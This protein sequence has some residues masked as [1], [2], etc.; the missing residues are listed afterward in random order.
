MALKI[1]LPEKETQAQSPPK[2]RPATPMAQSQSATDQ[3][4]RSQ[5]NEEENTRVVVC[6]PPESSRIFVSSLPPGNPRGIEVVTFYDDCEVLERDIEDIRP[7]VVLLSPQSRNY[8]NALVARLHRRSD[9]MVVVVGLVPPAG[10]WG[11]EMEA[12]GAAGFLTTP[13]TQETVDRFVRS[14]PRWIKA[15]AEERSSPAFLY[16]LTPQ[17]AAAM[18]AQGYQRGVYTSWSTKGGAGKTTVACNLASLLGVISQRPTLL[19]D[20][21]MNGGHVWLHMG[22]KPKRN[23]YALA[24][25]FRRNGNRLEPRD[26]ASQVTQYQGALDILVGIMRVEQ[27]GS[28]ALRGEQGRLFTEALLNLAQRQYDFVVI[29]LGSSPN[30]SVHLTCLRQSDRVLLVATP[31]RTALVDAKNTIETLERSLGFARDHFWLIVNMYSEE[32]GLQRKDIP[33]W[34]ELVEMGLIPLDPQ[35]RLMR[36]VNAGV[37]FVMEYMKEKN[38]DPAVRSVLEG[39]AGVAINIYP[40]FRAVWDDRHRRMKAATGEKGLKGLLQRLTEASI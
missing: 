6:A 31:D 30:V 14:I 29:D 10:D 2:A 34:I 27:A 22:L 1:G 26:L 19:I 23:I 9:F 17:T 12:S 37:P 11:E 24:E 4:Q 38:P 33:S 25:T 39:F 18:A 5:L 15:T 13:A 16:D 8:S 32:S 40:P 3:P 7:T 20:A 28:E 35:G 36:A 21:N